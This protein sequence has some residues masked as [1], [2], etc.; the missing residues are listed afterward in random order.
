MRPLDRSQE[1]HSA[2]ASAGS[3]LGDPGQA[4]PSALLEDILAGLDSPP[5]ENP[6]YLR[7]FET[8]SGSYV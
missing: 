6:P 8:V 7:I 2:R 4:K 3:T 1:S 5:L